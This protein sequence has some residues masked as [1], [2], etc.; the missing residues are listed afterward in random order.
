MSIKRVIW[1]LIALGNMIGIVVAQSDTCPQVVIDALTTVNDACSGIARNEVCYGNASVSA[2]DFEQQSIPELS[3]IGDQADVSNIASLT[4]SAFNDADGTWGIAIMTLQ[5]DLPDTI[6]GQNVTFVILGDVDLTQDNQAQVDVT[7][8]I[9][10]NSTGNI[11]VRAGT[12]ANSALVGTLATNQAVTAIGRNSAGD[13]LKI[14]FEDRT[15]WVFASLLTSE[16]DILSLPIVG[17][18]DA[19]F[20]A[21]MQVFS[22]QTGIGQIACDTV[23]PSGVLIQALTETT[24]HFLIN[25]IEVEIGS[26]AFIQAYNGQVFVHNLEGDVSVTTGGETISVDVGTVI[27]ANTDQLPSDPLPYD[28]DDMNYLPVSLLPEEVAVPLFVSP[29][30]DWVDSGVMI[31]AGT[32]Y[33]LVTGGLANYWVNCEAEKV[34]VGQADIDCTTLFFGPEGGDPTTLDGAILGSDMSLF[35]VPIAPPHSLVGRI[36]TETFFVGDGGVFTAPAT[37]TLEFRANDVDTNNAGGF[38]VGILPVEE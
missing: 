36:G 18:S 28:F 4:T 29:N 34:G 5:A 37:G 15:A 25:G 8:Q 7:S 19:D 11:N 38:L 14:D 32:M 21:P 26:T 6:A 10:A 24:V 1:M 17:T 20:S 13:W 16:D 2:E 12:S 35:P 30:S 31:E 22:L 33:R 3:A 27:S 23:P 9:S